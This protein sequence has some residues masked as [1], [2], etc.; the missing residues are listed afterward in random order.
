MPVVDVSSSKR[1]EDKL[2]IYQQQRISSQISPRSTQSQDSHTTRPLSSPARPTDTTV[3][4][5]LLAERKMDSK[6][7]TTDSEEELLAQ[8]LLTMSRSN[9]HK[10]EESDY[11]NLWDSESGQTDSSAVSSNRSSFQTNKDVMGSLLRTKV[12]R[13]H[14]QDNDRRKAWINYSESTMSSSQ[15]ETDAGSMYPFDMDKFKSLK[16]KANNLDLT[17]TDFFSDLKHSNS[18]LELSKLFTSTNAMLSSGKE[19][20][21]LLS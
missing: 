20:G 1:K 7:V 11:A 18:I 5:Q 12:N 21:V 9:P 2:Q 16:D 15:T 8:I 4:L 14:S 13:Q 19:T 3:P 10:D 6:R 17:L